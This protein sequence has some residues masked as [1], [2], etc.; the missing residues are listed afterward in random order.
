M[1]SQFSLMFAGK[2]GAY[3]NESAYLKKLKS[4]ITSA[5]GMVRDSQY[6]NT[7]WKA[8]SGQWLVL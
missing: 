1:L 8:Y 5:M 2:D 6:R 7:F 3:T 4:F